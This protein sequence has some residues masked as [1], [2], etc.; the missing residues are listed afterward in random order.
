LHKYL[1]KAGRIAG[2][3]W[4]A[5][6]G[7]ATVAAILFFP[8]YMIVDR[9]SPPGDYWG[10]CD[11]G[12]HQ[13]AVESPSQSLVARGI[14]VQCGGPMAAGGAIY[15]VIVKKGEEP[16]RADEVLAGDWRRMNEAKLVWQG[17]QLLHI[18]IPKDARIYNQR[19]T[20]GDITIRTMLGSDDP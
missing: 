16:T 1:A 7:G 4:V 3:S 20:L 15:I 14:Y 17:D 10:E 5:L 2:I 6:I 8:V 19:K 11:R 18:T 9:L 13:I 12:I